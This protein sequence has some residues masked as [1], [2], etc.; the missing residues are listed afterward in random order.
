MSSGTSNASPLRLLLVEDDTDQTRLLTELFKLEGFQVVSCGSV[1]TA[2]A[3]AQE[4]DF[5]VAIVDLSLPDQSGL[6]LAR[7]FCERGSRTRIIVYTGYGTFDTLKQG[8]N[9]RVYA[10]VE[11]SDDVR[12]LIEQVQRAST[13]YLNETLSQATA[14]LRFQLHLLDSVDEGV[15]ATD[16]NRRITF[17]NRFST[18]VLG[19]PEREMR[20]DYWKASSPSWSPV[21]W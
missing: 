1:E 3:F 12:V 16:V 6:E 10:Y 8:L 7:V 14:E 5:A 9:L 18:Q 19:L 20:G 21:A 4:G 17:S 13:E 11:K 2:L 15:I